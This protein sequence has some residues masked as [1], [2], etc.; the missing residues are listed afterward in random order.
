MD[1][2]DEEEDIFPNPDIAIEYVGNLAADRG[3]MEE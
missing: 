3:K 1:N 2:S